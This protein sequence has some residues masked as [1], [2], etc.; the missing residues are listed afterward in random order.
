MSNDKR[1]AIEGAL[2]KEVLRQRGATLRWVDGSQNV[3]DVLTKLSVDKTYLY[4][5]L[6]EARWS[7]VQDQAAARAKAAKAAKRSDNRKDKSEQKGKK[8]AAQQ[9]R[10]AAEMRDLAVQNGD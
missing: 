4:K 6:R 3:A 5:V 7:L 10:R 9:Q 2:L 1:M 8:V